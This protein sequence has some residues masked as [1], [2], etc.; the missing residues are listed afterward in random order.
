[1]GRSHQIAIGLSKNVS[2]LGKGVCHDIK[3][4]KSVPKIGLSILPSAL[5]NY[6]VCSVGYC[7]EWSER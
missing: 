6:I 2:H 7:I 3:C 5:V 4:H 1:M